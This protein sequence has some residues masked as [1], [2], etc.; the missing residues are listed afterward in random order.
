MKITQAGVTNV[1]GNSLLTAKNDAKAAEAKEGAAYEVEVSED[2][3]KRQ[4]AEAEE[5]RKAKLRKNYLSP[6]EKETLRES[7]ISQIEASKKMFSAMKGDY[8]GVSGVKGTDK[9]EDEDDEDMKTPKEQLEEKIAD[10]QEK[11]AK[12]QGEMAS[13]PE[14]AAAKEAELKALTSQLTELQAQL[15]EIMKEDES[16]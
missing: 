9:T 14:A 8:V 4:Q 5:L 3:I 12:L 1:A 15:V 13:S 11:I 16:E 7:A 10:I 2:A 6:E